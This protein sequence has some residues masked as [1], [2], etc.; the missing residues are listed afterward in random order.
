MI[1]C[2]ISCIQFDSHEEQAN[3]ILFE[4]PDNELMI[5]MTLVGFVD[6]STSCTGISEKESLADLI[7]KMREDAQ[8]WHD[9]LWCSG[10]KLELSKCGYHIIHYNFDDSGIPKMMH[11]PSEKITLKDAEGGDVNIVGKSIYQPRLNLGHLKAPARTGIKHFNK[12]LTNATGIADA[13]VKCGG[14]RDESR[15]YY[16]TVW[17][18]A[19]EYTLSQSFLSEKQLKKIESSCL[20]KIISKCGYNRNTSRAVL[21]GPANLTGGGI[22]PLVATTGAG[23]VLHFIKN[24]RTP[25]EDIGRVLRIVYAW[26]Q[27]Q[28]GVSFPLL[29]QPEEPITYLQGKVIPSLR[30][31]LSKIDGKLKLDKTYIRK[32]LR[33][34]DIAIMDIVRQA[35][36]TEVQEHRINCVR[37]FLGVM[38]FSEICTIDGTTI[39]D[40]ITTG[41]NDNEEYILTLKKAIQHRP[42]TRSWNLWT[43]AITSITSD[44]KVLQESL[45]DWTTNHSTSGRWNAYQHNNSVYQSVRHENGDRKWRK[46]KRR[47]SLIRQHTMI[48]DTAFDPSIG[49]PINIK[50]Y[51]GR[52]TTRS[53]PCR[54]IVDIHKPKQYGPTECWERF[55]ASQSKWIRQFLEE[56]HFYSDDGHQNI[57]EILTL[58]DKGGHLLSV[59]D[60]SVKFHNMSFGWIIATPDGRRLAAGCGPCEGRVNSLRAEGAGMLFRIT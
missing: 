30:E 24:W 13:V 16:D 29:E 58:H 47:G 26:C 51:P 25:N 7:R 52:F 20:P 45:G 22:I 18:P 11:H 27:Y 43:Q 44:G 54:V 56:V 34:N 60:G 4:S 10:G 36:F 38:Y 14:T 9:L 3:G 49:I 37:L 28:A 23:E 59:S 57:D 42:N 41:N 21:G 39:R 46:Y 31:Y 50:T 6:D 19:V 2:F 1:W 35:G 48:D 17:R 12:V 15:M 32:K 33:A 53:L 5:K 55:I 8:L 40:G